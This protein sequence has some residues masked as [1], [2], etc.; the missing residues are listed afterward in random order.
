MYFRDINIQNLLN[1]V[2][3]KISK[4]RTIVE[5]RINYNLVDEIN[6]TLNNIIIGRNEEF[7]L[8]PFRRYIEWTRSKE[9]S[10]SVDVSN[11]LFSITMNLR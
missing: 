6:T 4:K 1:G 5:A 10:G 11:L 2:H 3:L 9:G 7:S 8:T